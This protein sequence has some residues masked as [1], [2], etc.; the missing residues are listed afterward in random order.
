MF[1]IKLKIL[2]KKTQ[3]LIKISLKYYSV[4]YST[5]FFNNSHNSSVI[6]CMA[7]FVLISDFNLSC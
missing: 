6:I 4:Y 1:E 5:Y 3:D 2:K 7:R